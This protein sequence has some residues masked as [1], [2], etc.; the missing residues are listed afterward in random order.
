MFEVIAQLLNSLVYIDYKY[1]LKGNSIKNRLSLF[2]LVSIRVS[3]Y[4][5]QDWDTIWVT[6]SVVR[7]GLLGLQQENEHIKDKHIKWKLLSF[8]QTLPKYFEMKCS[9]AY[10]ST[11][12]IIFKIGYRIVVYQSFCE[13]ICRL[14]YPSP[15]AKGCLL[16][17]DPCS[18]MG[19][20]EQHP[21]GKNY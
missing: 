19:W 13:G 16:L 7:S 20:T 21:L 11:F 12:N 4:H 1:T 10:K 17:L 14:L 8:A 15:D 2:I 5:R 18:E 6:C 3:V 9:N